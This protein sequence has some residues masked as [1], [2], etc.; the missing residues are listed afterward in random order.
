MENFKLDTVQLDI[1]NNPPLVLVADDNHLNRDLLCRVLHREGFRT[2]EADDGPDAINKAYHLHPNLILLDIQMPLMSGFEVIKV[3]RENPSTARIPI[4]VITAA[5]REPE[6]VVHGLGLGADDYLL[7]PFNP[8]E[9]VARVVTK[10]KAHQLEESLRKRTEELEAL[11]RVGAELNRGLA[12]DDLATRLLAGTM[13]QFK[14]NK[15]LLVLFDDQNQKR[16]LEK[17]VGLGKQKGDWLGPTTLGGL[18]LSGGEAELISEMPNERIK[19][20]IPNANCNSGIATPIKHQG[21]LLGVLVLGD[22]RPGHFSANDLRVLRSIGEQTALAIRNAHLF[23]QLQEY[24]HGLESMVE[25]RTAAL[26]SAQIQL[27]R[28]EKL[29]ALGTLAAGVAHEVNNPLQPILSSLEMAIE[30]IDA[31]RPADRELLEHAMSEVVRIRKIV[32]NLL[33]FAR[34]S[35]TGPTLVAT[36]VNTLMNEV[37]SLA[38][39]QF[40]VAGI[41]LD[42][43]FGESRK[44]VANADQL[45]QVFLNLVVNAMDAMKEGGTLL[46]TT[47][48][49]DEFAV[50]TVQ[51]TGHGIPKDALQKV[52]DPFFTTKPSGTGLGLSVSHSIIEGHGGDIT[53]ESKVGKGTIFT[54]K[55]PLAK[56]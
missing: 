28:T 40:Q 22:E 52:F 21:A 13:E 48:E 16:I 17:Q 12:L 38:N 6:D 34:P 8:S 35:P 14:A 24:A 43:R 30:D 4:V 31:K 36:D 3:L 23:A 33:D 51:D 47:S 20:I 15:A 50:I 42:K 39:K 54:I 19:V 27:M 32:S 37:L 2:D 45:K 7:K 46:V 44:I 1:T 55:L 53:V 29:A 26:Q 9:L 49:K 56:E 5:A 11:V 41:K 25:A 18:I 10:L